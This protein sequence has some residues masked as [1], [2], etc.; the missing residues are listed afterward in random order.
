MSRKFGKL[1]KVD[2]VND[3][4]YRLLNNPA[5]SLRLRNSPKNVF[6]D[7]LSNLKDQENQKLVDMDFTVLCLLF[8]CHSP[9]ERRTNKR[10]EAKSPMQ[11]RST[12]RLFFQ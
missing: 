8:L 7:D 5:L 9:L 10:S 2:H 12:L 6:L 3:V 1:P 4:N 11:I